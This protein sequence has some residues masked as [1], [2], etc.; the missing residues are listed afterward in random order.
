MNEN[1]ALHVAFTLLGR[2]GLGRS[3]SLLVRAGETY[4]L[5]PR[6]ARKHALPGRPHPVAR[7]RTGSPPGSSPCTR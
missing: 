3:G 7:A 6:L 5:N 4:V 1:V 2:A